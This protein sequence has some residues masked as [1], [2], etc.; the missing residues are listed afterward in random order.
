MAAVSKLSTMVKCKLP[1]DV[2]PNVHPTRF[3]WRQVVNTINGTAVQECEGQLPPSIERA[4]QDIITTAKRLLVD[5]AELRK[6]VEELT[7]REEQRVK[8]GQRRVAAAAPL[9]PSSIIPPTKK[10]K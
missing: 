3:K 7:K 8:E 9:A 1:I 4:V 6:Q 10:S 2:V 5:N